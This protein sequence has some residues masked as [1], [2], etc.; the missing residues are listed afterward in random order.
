MA[1]FC[2]KC[3]HELFGDEIKPEIDVALE[4]SGLEDGCCIIGYLCEGCALRAIAK[5]GGEL[6]VLRGDDTDWQNY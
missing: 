3:T 6:K 5:I 1:D 4:Y 2:T